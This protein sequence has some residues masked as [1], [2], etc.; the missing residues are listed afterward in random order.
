M[1]KRNVVVVM[2]TYKGA[3]NV[4]RQLD[5]IF[6][7]IG[8]N[9]SVFIRDDQS[10]DDTVKVIDAYK[11]EH[12]DRKID[13]IVGQNEGYA[14]SFLD[15]LKMAGEAD[16]YAFSD[17]DDVWKEDKLIKSIQPMEDSKGEGPKLS[18]CKMQRTDEELTRLSEQVHVL[19]LNE[20]SKKLV[21]TQTYNYG[22]ATVFNR[23]ARELI[24][25]RMPSGN[26]VPHDFWAGLLCYWFGKVFFIDEEL[27][28]W[29]RY[30]TSVTGEGTKASGRAYRLKETLKKRSYLNVASDLL[31]G[32]PDL[33]E[34]N[35]QRFLD[36]LTRYKKKFKLKMRLLLD[37]EFKRE[38]WGG[39]IL[40]KFGI[41][42]NWF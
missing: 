29:I 16:Y 27:Y 36:A 26:K 18:Y 1:D 38:K 33:L 28:D 12:P 8:V 15:A 2:S 4:S 25:R 11:N 41:L 20:L 19:E 9:V 3:L 31:E 30:E 14:K 23:E 13:Y 37:K 5:S 7:Q 21:L 35:D 34:E 24:C 6:S 22:A 40:L 42:M 32:Y 39:T 17:Q 10:P